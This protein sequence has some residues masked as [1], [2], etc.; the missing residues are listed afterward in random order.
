M[1]FHYKKNES[2]EDSGHQWSSYSDLF[3]AL[4]VVFLLLYVTASL[5]QGTFSIQKHHEYQRL[6]QQAEDLKQ[7]IKVYSTLKEDYLQNGANQEDQQ[8]YAEL[9]DKLKLLKEQAKEEKNQLRQQAEENEKKEMALNKY[10]QMIRNIVNANLVAQ[11][12]IKRRDNIIEEKDTVI[13]EKYSEIKGLKQDI[14]SKKKAIRSAE[15]KMARVEKVLESKVAQLEDS[16]ARQE[17]SKKK[18]AQAIK[19]IR[20]QSRNQMAQLEEEAE[21]TTAQ[22]SQAK[23][24]L[25]N[26]NAQLESAKT[27]MEQEREQKQKALAKLQVAASEAE[28][29]VNQLKAEFDRK[30]QQE[31]EQ[32]EAKMKRQKLSAL[33]R[34]KKEA[35][36]ARQVAQREKELK[37]K[38]ASLKGQMAQT[39]SQLKK[40]QDQAEARQRLAREIK[41]NLARAG[42][43]AEVDG[44]TG[45]VLIDFGDHY[46]DTGKSHLKSEMKRILEKAL[47]AYSQG[48][49]DN[50]KIA[51]K[52]SAVEIVGFASPTFQG[53]YVDPSSLNPEDRKAV[54]Y[55][56]DLSFKRARSIFNHVFDTG[57]MKFQ[58]QKKLLPLVKVTGRSFLAEGEKGRGLASGSSVKDYCKQYDCKKAQKVIIRFNLKD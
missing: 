43:K 56:L 35:E 54:D 29:K 33:N 12:R 3:M 51:Q 7:Q 46:F 38:M 11:A 18:Y 2:G 45:D 40:A 25:A 58:Y 53:K 21:K 16:Y 15:R 42:V 6:A 26:V 4:S 5:R 44:R 24:R 37:A 32:F 28:A 27:A 41:R 31:R 17:I 1:S 48:L 39:Q 10:Q 22:L 23:S 9:M 50:Q 52:I 49:F 57:K 8:V 55:N 20:Q 34:A 47:P 13:S 36:F 14:H 30:S 19:K